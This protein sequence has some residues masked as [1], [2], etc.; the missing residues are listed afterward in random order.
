MSIELH[1]LQTK[2]DLRAAINTTANMLHSSSEDH[3]K[4]RSTLQCRRETDSNS[5]GQLMN[6]SEAADRRYNCIGGELSTSGLNPRAYLAQK[7]SSDN[8]PNRNLRWLK[9]FYKLLC[10]FLRESCSQSLFAKG[11]TSWALHFHWR[12]SLWEKYAI[13]AKKKKSC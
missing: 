6:V 13:P 3:Y 11:F 9:P 2:S 5:R 7:S 4:F 10:Q 1:R 8:R 12:C